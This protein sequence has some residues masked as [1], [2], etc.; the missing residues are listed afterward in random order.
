MSIIDNFASPGNLFGALS[1]CYRLRGACH[2]LD[3]DAV[4]VDSSGGTVYVADSGNGSVAVISSNTGIPTS[5]SRYISVG[6]PRGGL[7]VA[8]YSP[9][10]ASPRSALMGL[11]S[12]SAPTPPSS[13]RH[14]MRRAVEFAVSPATR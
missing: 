5:V 10:K 12:A 14:P 13:S 6:A 4:A 7:R 1:Q 2:H 8:Q 3:P 9:G 11:V